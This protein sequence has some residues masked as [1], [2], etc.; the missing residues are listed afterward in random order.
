[1]P[2]SATGETVM[3]EQT[4]ILEVQGLCKSYHGARVLEPVSFALRSGE[5]LGIVGANGSGKSTLLRLI[6]QAQKPDSGRVL[7]RGKAVDR[8]FPRRHLGY[9]PQALELAPELTVKEQLALWRAACGAR[10][11]VS[12]EITALLGLEPLM[13]RRIGTLSGGMQRRVS[14]GMALSTGQDVLVL[15]EATAGLD[16]RYRAELLAWMRTFLSRGGC[17][18]WCTHQDDELE[19]IC[20]SCMTIREGSAFWGR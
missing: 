19:Q 6:A 18:V 16:E 2:S 11:P 20:T 13:S 12:G 5:C 15:D 8:S 1:M 4:V 17:A 9:V 10:G 7:F 14:I 3:T